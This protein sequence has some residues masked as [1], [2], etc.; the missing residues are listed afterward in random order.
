MRQGDCEAVHHMGA[1]GGAAVYAVNHLAKEQDSEGTP[2]VVPGRVMGYISLMLLPAS[3]GDQWPLNQSPSQKAQKPMEPELSELGS[4]R[5]A[6]RRNSQPSLVPR[7]SLSAHKLY[8][9]DL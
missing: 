3:A 7:L 9:R 4:T 5:P 6:G 1:V 8:A 2:V